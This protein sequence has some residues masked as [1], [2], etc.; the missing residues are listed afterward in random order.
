V[1]FA[2]EQVL[3][4]TFLEGVPCNRWDE[5]YREEGYD[6]Q[7]SARAL[8]TETFGPPFQGIP[9]PVHADPH[10]ANLIIM[11]RGRMGVVD[12]GLVGRISQREIDLHN[13]CVFAIYAQN[14]ERAVEAL[15][16]VSNY[17][18]PN[19]K[20]ERA[21]VRAVA[22][23]VKECRT[24]PFDYW[25]LEMGAIVMRHGIP[26]PAVMALLC[27]FGVLGNSVVQMFFPG[28]STIDLVGE[29]IRAGMRKQMLDRL[30]NI[31]PVPLLY[32][33]TLRA[34]QLPRDA[35]EAV[36]HPL[37]TLAEAVETVFGPLRA[38]SA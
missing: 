16:L 1:E 24:Q 22:R 38:K 30:A 23:F 37:E 29:Q 33:L 14:V 2:S 27:R 32:E 11:K 8:L 13:D 31:D 4:E 36:R 19:E 34:E 15:L 9:V 10:P 3:I 17:T 7:A 28:L 5:R 20:K 35:A 21:F 18:F 6:P 25:L 12:F 26:A